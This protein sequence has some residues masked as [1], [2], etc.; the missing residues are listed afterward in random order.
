MTELSGAM[1]ALQ[2][3]DFNKR[4]NTNAQGQY[5]EMLTNASNAMMVF[6]QVIG[7]IVEVMH[8]MSEGDFN[9]RV[10]VVAYGDL[11]TM[12]DNI[13]TSMAAIAQ[14]IN[15]I[16]EVVAAQ[17]MGDLTKELPT[18]SFKGQLHDLKN[19][20]NYSSSKVKESVIQAVLASNIVNAASAQVSQG[21]ADLSSRVQEQAA[22]LEETSSTMHQ[23]ATAVQTNTANAKRAAE[24]AQQV[25]NQA[26]AGVDVMQQTISAMQS[27]KASSG[28]IADI[29]TIIDSIAFQTNLLALNAAV[30]AARAGEHGRGFAV[31]ASEVRA[32]AQKSADAAKDIKNLISDSVGRIEVGTQLADKSGAM[33]GGITDSVQQV[34]SMIGEIAHAS[35]EQNAGIGQVHRAI[36]EIDAVT[37]QNAALVEETSSAAESLSAE[38]NHLRENMAFFKTGQSVGTNLNIRPAASVG[39]NLSVRPTRP[40]LPAP[41]KTNTTEWGEF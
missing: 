11:L 12:K 40:S 30:E 21:S 41:K 29:V 3:G 24:L 39:A 4:L 16:S 31:V 6:N 10:R 26:G 35:A 25:Q 19:A 8:Q 22:A 18:G 38:A 32:L 17:A 33:L 2:A 23:M 34:A 14:A 36:A 28:K 13:N 20:I 7:E 5:G 9:S 1:M 27:I 15:A 37:Q